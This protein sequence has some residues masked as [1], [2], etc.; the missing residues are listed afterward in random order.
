MFTSAFGSLFSMSVCT[1]NKS[2]IGLESVNVQNWLTGHN[3]DS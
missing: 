1:E 3:Y 2:V